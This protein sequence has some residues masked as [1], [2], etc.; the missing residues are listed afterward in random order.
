MVTR[1]PQITTKLEFGAIWEV[2][3]V[4]MPPKILTN[5]KSMIIFK[6]ISKPIR[7]RNKTKGYS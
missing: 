7:K 5:P 4:K 1:W 2:I 3:L 6:N